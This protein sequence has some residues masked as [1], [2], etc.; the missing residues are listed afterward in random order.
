MSH[1]SSMLPGIRDDERYTGE[2]AEALA[3][4]DELDMIGSSGYYGRPSFEPV[5]RFSE[6]PQRNYMAENQRLESLKQQHWYSANSAASE[7]EN[8][9]QSRRHSFAGISIANTN[10]TN[11]GKFSPVDR[12]GSPIS[13]V[14]MNTLASDMGRGKLTLHNVFYPRIRLTCI[15]VN[16]ERSF[17]E[18]EAARRRQKQQMPLHLVQQYAQMTNISAPPIHGHMEMHR[19]MLPSMTSPQSRNSQLLYLVSFKACRADI[20]YVQE[21]TGLRVKNGDL[22]IVEADRGTD[23]GTVTGENVTWQQAKDLKEQAAQQH[24]EW[25]MKFSTRRPST[26]GAGGGLGPTP[27]LATGQD[28]GVGSFGDQ[29]GPDPA[30]AELKPK[31]IKRL[32]QVHEIQTLRD[33]EANEAKAKRVC[34]QKVLEHRLPMEILDAEFQM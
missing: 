32:A 6:A 34:Q 17:L 15:V 4:E 28:N 25:L 33:K 29:Q 26:A 1:G 10:A 8:G 19:G 18:D 20:F 14:D 7:E 2:Y 24:F 3:D 31:M 30:A 22:V 9:S 13:Y 23:L 5:R 27:I 11:Y 21:G 12:T 16:L